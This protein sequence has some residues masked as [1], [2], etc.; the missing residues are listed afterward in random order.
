MFYMND[1]DWKKDGELKRHVK[2]FFLYPV[3]WDDKKNEFTH[4]HKKWKKI[5]FI[6]A[7]HSK[8]PSKRGV[9]AFAL[10]P[11][12]KSLFPTNY[13]FYVGKT[14]RTLKE[15]YKEYIRERDSGKKYRI[16]VK[17]MLKQYD[18][19]LYF[20]YLEL[21][22]AKQVTESENVLLNTFV[23]HINVQIPKAKIDP[24]LKYIYE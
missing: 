18:G 3:F 23:P 22:T 1:I 2:K 15:R 19:Y 12:Y 11:S 10:K 7:N 16:K 17:K 20:Y 21:N 9:Y 14:Q 13:L 6:D 5:K 8:I 4:K 24:L